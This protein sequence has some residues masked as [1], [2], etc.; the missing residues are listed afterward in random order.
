MENEKTIRLNRS[1]GL[2]KLVNAGNTFVMSPRGNG[3][4]FSIGD[5][6]EHLDEVMP[7]SQILILADT[8]KRLEDKI[9]PNICDYFINHAGAVEGDDFVIYKKPPAH[10]AKPLIPLHNYEHVV[11]FSSGMCLC[12][13]SGHTEGN[14]NAFNA[15]AMIVDE[16]KF[17]KESHVKQASL[18]LRGSFNLFGALPEYR[19]KWF[20][21][22]KYPVP[23]SNIKWLLN[24]KQLSAPVEVIDS[25]VSLQQRVYELDHIIDIAETDWEIYQAKNKRKQILDYLNTIRK[26]LTFYCD[27]LPLENLDNLG[28]KYYRDQKRE[29]T[30]YEY[31]I[32][33]L[34]EDPDVV[35]NSFY[36]ALNSDSHYHSMMDDINLDAPLAIALDY[37]WRI[38]PM[39]VAQFGKLPGAQHSTLNVV[40]GVHT[41]ADGGIVATCKAFDKQFK[42]MMCKVVWY[43]F[44]HT[45][46]GNSPANDAFY[47][48]VTNT[49]QELG[50]TVV[51]V[52]TGQASSHDIRFET[53]KEAMLRKGEGA[54]Q[55]NK[56]RCQFL[57]LSLQQAGAIISNG[58][59]K[60]DK[61]KEKDLRFPAEET[62][63]YSEAFDVLLWGHIQQQFLSSSTASPGS[64]LS[65]R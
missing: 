51:H 17:V 2:I 46:V 65:I 35:E 22:D 23:G 3:K 49:L 16:A 29:L 28:E 42:H 11:A 15:Q 20:F 45:A 59:T 5:R 53:I 8:Y 60:K 7:R 26:D 62:T 25:I 34:N 50:W 14:A 61:S 38:T 30:N 63:D 4:T 47:Q 58:Q 31:K 36:P 43:V 48:I 39:V 33:I 54:I 9:V 40:A 13:V 27:G 6:I 21:T 41:L 24:K 19:S 32:A 18:V 57:L 52:Y 55:F 12:L 37:N 10:F 44:D 64:G 1:Q 56:E